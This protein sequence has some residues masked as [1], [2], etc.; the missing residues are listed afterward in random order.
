VRRALA[1]AFLSACTVE[2]VFATPEASLERMIDQPKLDAYEASALFA[3]GR[4]MQRPPP[5]TVPYAK[6]PLDPGF[7]F[8]AV[9]GAYLETIPIAVDLALLARGRDRF[10]IFCAT[11]H[12]LAGDAKSVV[13]EQMDLVRPRSLIGDKVRGYPPGRIFR[14]ARE[15]FGLMPSYRSAISTRD[16]WAVVAYVQ[17]LQLRDRTSL[18]S[19]PHALAREAEAELR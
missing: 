5:G 2:G 16:R 9:D 10:E 19:L 11:C 13:A 15:G 3:D 14:V 18:R 12:G 1:A 7:E 8:G 4:A 6:D 17:A